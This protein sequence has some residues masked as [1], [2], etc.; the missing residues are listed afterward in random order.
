VLSAV[1]ASSGSAAW[2]TAEWLS[3]GQ[4]VLTFLG[5]LLAIIQLWRTANATVASKNLLARRLLSND[6]LVLIPELHALED[7]LDSA[8][9]S[10]DPDQVERA[11]VAYFRAAG[12]I[13]GH[14]EAFAET[15]DE[16]MV[17]LLK[18]SIRTTRSAKIEIAT[19]PTRSLA[20]ITRLPREKIMKVTAEAAALVGRLQKDSE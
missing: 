18:Q 4:L 9:K 14:L 10:G 15:K 6:L 11:L 3:L 12:R 5:F 19:G 17:G 16:L 2:S 8:A 20:E 7:S 1:Q 13:Q